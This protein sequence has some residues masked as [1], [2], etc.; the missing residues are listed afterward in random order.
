[1][2]DAGEMMSD[3]AQI[4]FKQYHSV[5][6]FLLIEKYWCA[7][8]DECPHHYFLSWG[9]M[10]TWL[11]SL[12]SQ[13]GVRLI[14]GLVDGEPVLA[15]FAG[16][17]NKKWGKL[18]RSRVI[19]LNTTGIPLFDKIYLEYNAVLIQPGLEIDT[20]QLL[21]ALESISWDEFF[22]PGLSAQFVERMGNLLDNS[23][24]FN[25]VLDRKSVV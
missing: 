3:A 17:S 9:W 16:F 12:P 18:F 24:K 11:K 23:E 10:S 5:N 19:S 15:F 13:N 2:R 25:M 4:K 8:L 22:L 1:M 6:D 7:L 14:V 20:E 21:H